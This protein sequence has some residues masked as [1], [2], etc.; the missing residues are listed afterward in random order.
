LLKNYQQFVFFK[1]E[2]PAALRPVLETLADEV[3]TT[4]NGALYNRALI[5]KAKSPPE[6]KPSIIGAGINLAFGVVS[7]IHDALP[8]HHAILGPEDRTM[9]P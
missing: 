3:I 6:S 7:A 4:T 5:A 1:I 9:S 2:N 8:A